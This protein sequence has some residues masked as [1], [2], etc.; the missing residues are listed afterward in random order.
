MAYEVLQYVFGEGWQNCWQISHG[1]GD[2][3]PQTFKTRKAAQA[4]IDEFL[5]DIEQEIVRGE[6]DPDEGYSEEDFEIAKVASS[7]RNSD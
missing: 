7:K 4:E 2:W 3:R 5:K 1:N 6:R